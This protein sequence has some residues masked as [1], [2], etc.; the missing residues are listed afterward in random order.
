[1]EIGL[2][3][4][5]AMAIFSALHHLSVSVATANT[6]NPPTSFSQPPSRNGHGRRL[7]R[8]VSILLEK[9]TNFFHDLPQPIT[10]HLNLQIWTTGYKGAILLIRYPDP[11][12][13]SQATCAASKPCNSSSKM[14]CSFSRIRRIPGSANTSPPSIS[15][16]TT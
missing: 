12:N 14:G 2:R 4:H 11:C 10:I 8:A 16:F 6:H 7:R 15:I 3:H 5:R 1:M 13:I 9:L